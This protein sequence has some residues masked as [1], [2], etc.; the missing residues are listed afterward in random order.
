MSTRKM[1][2][3]KECGDRKKSIKFVE[4]RTW[5]KREIKLF[6]S[7]SPSFSHCS[8]Q[9]RCTKNCLF[10]TTWVWKEQTASAIY[11]EAFPRLVTCVGEVCSAS[12]LHISGKHP[13]RLSKG[14]G[15]YFF[16]YLCIHVLTYIHTYLCMFH[17]TTLS[18]NRVSTSSLFSNPKT[19]KVV[20]KTTYWV[21]G[22]ILP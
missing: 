4:N 8:E 19:Y 15:S 21:P 14:Q 13:I 16:M 9:G 2:S 11:P 5:M 12:D 6:S 22:S 10:L 7:S 20:H 18:R 3:G 1:K 17:V